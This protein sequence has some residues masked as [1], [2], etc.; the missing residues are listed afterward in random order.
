MH[1]V[2]QRHAMP[3][4]PECARRLG[5]GL[6]TCARIVHARNTLTRVVHTRL[7]QATLSFP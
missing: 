4:A 1:V 7:F 2:V 3:H 5:L 6:A